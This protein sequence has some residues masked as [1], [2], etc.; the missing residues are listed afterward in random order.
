MAARSARFFVWFLLAA[1]V[2]AMFLHL[3]LMDVESDNEGQR[4]V[5]PLEMLASR[6]Y[7]VP[8]LDGQPYLK[9]PPLL[10]WAI[11]GVYKTTGVI[12]PWTARIPT[13]VC[14]VSLVLC[15]YLLL[16]GKAGEMPARWAALATLTSPYFLQ[17]ARVA[18]LDVSLT[19]AVFLAIMALYEA[20]Q[21]SGR[22]RSVFLAV[23]GGVAFGAAILLKGPVPFLFVWA[24]WVG[25]GVANGSG[26]DRAMRLG[27]LWSAFALLFDLVL[28]AAGL[29]VP[30]ANPWL[31]MPL[32][33]VTTA[34]VW[35]VL[36]WR[37][38]GPT[39]L[40]TLALVLLSCAV[41]VAVA[42]PWAAAVLAVKG[43]PYVSALLNEEVV[44]R[45][46]TATSINSGNTLF[47]LAALAV[48]LAPWGFLLPLQFSPSQWRRRGP[49][50]RFT[51]ATGWVAVVAFSLIAGKEREYILPAI[52]LLLV[53]TGCHLAE[54][55]PVERWV[56]AWLHSW[57]RVMVVLLPIAAVGGA[58]YA[59]QGLRDAPVVVV[60]TWIVALAVSLLAIFAWRHVM[61]YRLVVSAMSL[62][63]F[64]IA[65]VGQGAHYRGEHSPKAI[66]A[67]SGELAKAGYA[68]ELCRAFPAF[69][70]YARTPIPVNTDVDSVV[71]KLRRDEPY[72]YVVRKRDLERVRDELALDPPE[73]IMGPY[74]RKGLLLIGNASLPDLPGSLVFG[75]DHPG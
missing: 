70:F 2:F 39:R 10:Y 60:E 47:Y 37:Y 29:L 24:A 71:E 75:P 59:M 66:G 9:K 56:A 65:L 23:L 52:P 62:L 7:L 48:L 36:A 41:A 61:S 13:A 21:S 69:V 53:P 44:E 6:D 27:L 40:R 12:S 22:S 28:K 30:A 18:G 34:A 14:G 1:A 33:L 42:A 20:W 5:P 38:G 63:L 55:V 51:L 17:R 15:V 25:F 64:T 49:A 3:G 45:T 43:W 35:T 4:A 58:V 11:A 16:R 57:E 50:Y 73:T 26:P 19:L 8:T 74:W 67:V 54:T 31:S 46:H 68:I 72:Y 32:M